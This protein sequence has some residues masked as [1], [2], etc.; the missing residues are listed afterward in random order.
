MQ[1]IYVSYQHDALIRYVDI[2]TEG[3]L[4]HVRAQ[5]VRNMFND[6][7]DLTFD[8]IRRSGPN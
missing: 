6:Q 8:S 3:I 2:Y 7:S 5:E 4:E 1:D